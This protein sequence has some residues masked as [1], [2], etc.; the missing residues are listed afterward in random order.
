MMKDNAV[1]RSSFV[2]NCA[3]ATAGLV[4]KIPLMNFQKIV[5]AVFVA[6]LTVLVSG[7]S[8]FNYEWRQA[9]KKPVPGDNITGAWEGRWVSKANSHNDRLRALITQVDTNHYDVKF[10]A[11]YKKW[12][13][14]HFGYT[15]RMEA[16]PVTNG[17]VAFRGSEDLGALAG[18][19]YM[20][21]GHANPTNS[22]STYKSKYDRG[23]F[24]M[25]RP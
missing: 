17:V 2:L 10:H 22:F 16:K 5:T 4:S 1:A 9:A 18:G 25:T 7:C 6:L 8:T 15:V 11:A 20:Y 14:V 21:E 19:V 24:Q 12:I 3:G 13:T 23:T